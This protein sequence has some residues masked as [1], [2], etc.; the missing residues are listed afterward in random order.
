MQ[1]FKEALAIL[2]VLTTGQITMCNQKWSTTLQFAST[3][4]FNIFQLNI[5]GDLEHFSIFHFIIFRGGRS[6]THATRAAEG[7][8]RYTRAHLLGP[9]VDVNV[10]NW[11]MRVWRVTIL[12][13]T[14]GENELQEP[15]S[16]KLSLNF[17]SPS[18]ISAVRCHI[19]SCAPAFSASPPLC[20]L[21]VL[22]TSAALGSES[23]ICLHLAHCGL[24]LNAWQKWEWVRPAVIYYIW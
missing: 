16:G 21:S 23:F 7:P 8:T 6:Y 19:S 4:C 24:W 11:E 2:F 15:P 5:L 10:Y 14:R 3:K 22:L 18:V 13:V 17:P 9:K 12:L 20:S 1:I